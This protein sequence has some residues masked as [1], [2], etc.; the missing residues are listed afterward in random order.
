MSD[1]LREL[2]KDV[3]ETPGAVG[4]LAIGS[5]LVLASW[6]ADSPLRVGTLILLDLAAIGLLLYTIGVLPLRVVPL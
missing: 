4:M 2:I 3:I 1:T 6:I 5:L